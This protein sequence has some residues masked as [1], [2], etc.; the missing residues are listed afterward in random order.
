MVRPQFPVALTGKEHLNEN[1]IELQFQFINNEAFSFR[2]GQ[3]VQLLFDY[4]GE[5]Y[6][7]SYSIANSPE[8]FEQTR[9]LHIA[10][11]FVEGGVASAFFSHVGV[12]A[13]MSLLGP[14]GVLTLPEKLSGRL[15]LVGT[16]TGIAPYRS[17][18]PKLTHYATVSTP[19]TIIMGGRYQ[20]EL[21]Y[22]AEFEKLAQTHTNIDYRMC[23]SREKSI[24]LQ[25]GEYSGYV[26]QQFKQLD[27]N[28]AADMIYLCG[29]P[30]MVD[31]AALELKGM[32]FSSKQVRREKYVYSGH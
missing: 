22:L 32:Q 10:I 25:Q 4:E 29:N 19:V 21:I 2:A 3:F 9:T 31:D 14:F 8:L 5:G 15:V 1:T 28:S 11:S 16:G 23:L 6:K 18:M 26:Q 13:Q 17:M 20:H 24:N 12:G 27:L 30:N 7:R